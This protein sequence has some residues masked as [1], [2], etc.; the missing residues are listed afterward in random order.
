MKAN[1]Q[2]YTKNGIQLAMYP[3]ETMNITQGMNGAFSHK[4]R[5][6]ID[7]AGKDAGICDAFAP[8]DATVVWVDTGKA[9]SGVL[10]TSDKPVLCADGTERIINFYAFHD[11]DITDLFVGKKLKQG[12]VF[13]QEGTAGFATGNH[14][15]YQTS[16]K[17]YTGGYPLFENEFGGWTLKNECSPVDVFW[18]NDTIIRNARGY[19]WQVAKD[20][21]AELPVVQKT[22]TVRFGQTLTSIAAMYP[23]LTVDEIYEFNKELIGPNKNLIKVGQKLI[24]PE[25]GTVVIP[26]TPAPA[27]TKVTYTVVRGDTL[28]G[29]ANKFKGVTADQIYEANKAII[30]PNKNIIK[31]GMV[32]VIPNAEPIKPLTFKVGDKVIFDG[33]LYA[34]GGKTPLWVRGKTYTIQQ[35]R[36]NEA[37]LREIRSWVFTKDL[38]K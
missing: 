9:R 20:V 3:F 10:I 36:P 13:Y 33:A 14:V 38:T 37:L 31:V 11:N 16:D 12:E 26:T 6:A 18:A 34:T 23:P 7:E 2:Y 5:M 29:I 22:H 1:T 21:V 8:F 19:N 4:G 24:L 15:H 28:S 17:P 30:G 25:P 35:L 27:P 32:L